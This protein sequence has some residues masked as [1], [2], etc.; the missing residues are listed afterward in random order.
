MWRRRGDRTHQC[1]RL[2]R[3]VR[4]SGSDDVVDPA[5]GI[6]NPFQL[7]GLPDNAD[8][9]L[10]RPA[11]TK[12]ASTL[13]PDVIGTGDTV[14]FQKIIWAYRELSEPKRWKL[15]AARFRSRHSVADDLLG[16]LGQEDVQ[17]NVD[18]VALDMWENLLRK[19]LAEEKE[20]LRQ[21]KESS[22]KR[23]IEGIYEE[24]GINQGRPVYR[25]D[26][27]YNNSVAIYFWDERD[28]ADCDGWWIGSEVGG[29]M[30]FA[31]NINQ[32][33]LTPPCSGWRFPLRGPIDE[34]LRVTLQ[35]SGTIEL[36]F[37]RGLGGSPENPV[38]D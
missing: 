9:A 29:E 32:A 28:G 2:W 17:Q 35:P 30:L 10:I 1:F 31:F 21:S 33:F 3:S 14:A 38:L 7:L 6:E 13:H 22:V 8:S 18:D 36:W 34:S 37:A 16:L 15:W 12:L 20:K 25:K 19:R 11:F 5:Q 26:G 24:R 23:L 27:V 4:T